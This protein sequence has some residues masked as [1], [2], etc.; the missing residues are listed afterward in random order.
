MQQD[1]P[2]QAE[3]LPLESHTPDAERRQLTVMFCDLADSTK[4]SGQ[5]DPE[6][7]REVIRAYQETAAGVI[8]RYEGIL[9]STSEM[10]SWCILAGPKPMKMTH[11]EACMRG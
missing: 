10:A 11:S 7:L 2:I 6:D 8:Q 4:L 3:S 1:Q 5:L 9:P